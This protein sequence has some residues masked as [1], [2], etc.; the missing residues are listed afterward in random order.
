MAN[1]SNIMMFDDHDVRDDWAFREEDYTD[2][3]FDFFW[4]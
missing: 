2:G 4:G 1:A 3:T